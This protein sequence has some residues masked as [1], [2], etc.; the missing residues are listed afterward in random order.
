MKQLFEDFCQA[1]ITKCN[2]GLIT[3]DN[4]TFDNYFIDLHAKDVWRKMSE[5]EDEAIGIC[6]SCPYY[7]YDKND[8]AFVFRDNDGEIH[9]VHLTR[10][11]WEHY[12]LNCYSKEI[13][14]QLI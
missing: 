14:E 12:V 11:S 1:L 9:W 13:L 10:L 3:I 5:Y 2:D 7:K 6:F 8:V 4:H